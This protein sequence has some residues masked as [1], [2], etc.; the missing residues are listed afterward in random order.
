M[1]STINAQIILTSPETSILHKNLLRLFVIL[2]LASFAGDHDG[3]FSGIKPVV[4]LF[5]RRSW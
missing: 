5:G 2:S 1:K 3:K 4:R